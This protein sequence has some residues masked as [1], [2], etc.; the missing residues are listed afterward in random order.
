M[1]KNSTLLFIYDAGD[2]KSGLFNLNELLDPEGC[3]NTELAC[4]FGKIDYTPRE[5]VIQKI[6]MHC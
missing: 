5:E 2:E 3:G 4:M 1:N 6:L